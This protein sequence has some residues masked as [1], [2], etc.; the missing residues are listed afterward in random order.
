M[1]EQ[2]QHAALFKATLVVRLEE[3][4]EKRSNLSDCSHSLGEVTT[5]LTACVYISD[6]DTV[7]LLVFPWLYDAVEKYPS[8]TMYEGVSLVLTLPKHCYLLAPCAPEHL[9]HH[10]AAS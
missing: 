6:S 7:P 8:C 9:L 3:I 10:C 5:I 1:V 2:S 4:G